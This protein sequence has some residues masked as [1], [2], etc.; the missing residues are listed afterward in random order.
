MSL[1]MYREYRDI[2]SQWLGAVPAHWSV[3][4]LRFVVE[5]NPSK[6]E[7]AKLPNDTEVSF[8]PM[9]AIGDDGSL[10]LEKTRALQEVET[11]YTYFRD[12]DVT[13]AKITPCFENGKG[14]LMAGLLGGIG[15]GTT[16]LIVA[17]PKSGQASAKFLNW[18]FQSP[19]FRKQGEAWMYGA[20]G[21]KRVPDDFVRNC[22]WC[23]PPFMEQEA[24]SAFLDRETS[25]IDAL[26]AEQEK[27]LELLAE[28]RQATI[29]HAVTRGLNPDAPMKDS[30]VEW[31]GEVPEHWGVGGL[32]RIAKR[33]VVGIAE[34]ATHAYRDDGV[35]ILRSTNIRPGRI[36]GEILYLAPEFSADRDSKAIEAGDLVT[37]RTGNAG[38]T[39]V[40]PDNLSPCQC[41]TMLITTLK[42]D[43]LS[44]YYCLWMNSE[45]AMC[46]FQLEGW[47]TA[48]VNISVPIL[49]ALPVVMPPLN[50]QRAIVEFIKNEVDK[51]DALS[52]QASNVIG[53]LKERRSA[54][55]SAAVT[56]KIDVREHP[57]ALA[58]AA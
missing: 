41:F 52:R 2:G 16:E 32:A 18:I 15:F 58:A 12:G 13:V 45:A 21:Q 28:K 35:P 31:L 19:G 51:L 27:L 4:R 23:F 10:N 38:V 49:K 53:L 25:K 55:I 20:G 24:I 3:K 1:P 30:G 11:G 42:G 48:Q 5:L 39:A 43:N 34:A 37:V 56:G 44:E 7:L 17:R 46:Y 22:L 14:A 33:V 9:E 26:I 57:S 50:E 6:S 36:E 8:L 29:S 54:L 47:G 40:V